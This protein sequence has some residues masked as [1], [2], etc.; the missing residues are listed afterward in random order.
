ML[1][2][3][4]DLRS[5]I[6][7]AVLDVFSGND[8]HRATTR[9]IA[10]RARTSLSKLYAFGSTKDEV[11]FHFVGRWL[12][13]LAEL[14][15]RGMQGRPTAKERLWASIEVEFAFYDRDPRVPRALFLT[16][17]RGVWIR[18]RTYNS[19]V[20]RQLLR[21]IEIGRADGSVLTDI[22]PVSLAD[23]V[24][25][26]IDRAVISWLFRGRP[27]RLSDKAEDVF[28]LAWRAISME[29]DD[30]SRVVRASGVKERK[31]KA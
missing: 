22:D 8:F 4:E 10:A 9:E 31:V 5:R 19:P 7:E 13:Q 1:E 12:I 6:E 29:R 17:P 24:V 14:I 25:G 11:F 30:T 3:S 27:K 21:T 23:V 16:L 26:V 18:H 28:R 20:F 15:E 2:L